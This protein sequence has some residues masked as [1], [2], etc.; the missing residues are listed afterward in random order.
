MEEGQQNKQQED[1]G[2]AMHDDEAK[3]EGEG[4]VVE[5]ALAAPPD[6][7]TEGESEESMEGEARK[8]CVTDLS[9]M[10]DQGSRAMA[11]NDDEHADVN[12]RKRRSHSPS[13]ES[14]EATPETPKHGKCRRKDSDEESAYDDN[15]TTNHARKNYGL[16]QKGK[17]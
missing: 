1:Q 17:S 13:S 3:D 15:D 5:A 16:L 14:Q 2:V 4:N 10:E 8:L 12:E 7:S 11:G 9:T 6:S